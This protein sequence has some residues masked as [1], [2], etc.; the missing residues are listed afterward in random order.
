MM[1]VTKKPVTKRLKKKKP[2]T[3]HTNTKTGCTT[4]LRYFSRR[5]GS[6]ALARS[7]RGV[8]VDVIAVVEPSFH[9][10]PVPLGI[11]RALGPEAGVG[12]WR[13]DVLPGAGTIHRH[14]DARG[15]AAGTPTS[16]EQLKRNRR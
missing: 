12:T 7:R 6:Q 11:G 10:P 15:G 1:G 4:Y 13:G 3:E 9:V 16:T 8:V 14:G 2:V 5:V